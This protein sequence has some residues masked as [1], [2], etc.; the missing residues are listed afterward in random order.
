M[1]AMRHHLILT[2]VAGLAL[3]GCEQSMQMLTPGSPA[4]DGAWVGQ[5][6][7]VIKTRSCDVT[8]GG[9][10][11]T[12]DGGQLLGSVRFGGGRTLDLS[13]VVR[14][15]G[16]LRHAVVKMPNIEDAEIN[17]RFEETTAKGEWSSKE[18]RGTWELRKIR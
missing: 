11:A 3:A 1:R 18:C 10:R 17:G 12:I 2:V 9:L 8:R 13:G 14:E 5:I 15:G 4:Y 6:R 16:E 7:A